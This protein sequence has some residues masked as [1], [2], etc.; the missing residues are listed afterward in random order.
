MLRA[1]FVKIFMPTSVYVPQHYSIIASLGS[2]DHFQCKKH[3]L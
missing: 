2:K 1:Y 3:Y